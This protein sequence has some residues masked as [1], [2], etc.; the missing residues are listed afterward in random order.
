MIRRKILA[1]IALRHRLDAFGRIF[2]RSRPSRRITVFICYRVMGY[3]DV[4]ILGAKFSGLA[5]LGTGEKKK[6]RSDDQEQEDIDSPGEIED[7][8]PEKCGR[9]WD[10]MVSE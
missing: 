3:F 2:H 1:W 8:D 9:R 4:T 6:F 10:M 5:D 7:C